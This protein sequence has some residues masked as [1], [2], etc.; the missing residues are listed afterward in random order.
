MKKL[1]VFIS[2]LAVAV[3]CET[4]YGPVQ[5]PIEADKAGG[6]TIKVNSV[7]DNSASFTLTP[8]EESAYYSY[9]VDMADAA[10]ELDPSLLYSCKY[11]SIAQGTVKW[12]SDAPLKT[13]KIEDL[14]PNT[15]YQIYAVAGSP[16]GIAGDIAITSFKTSD[17]VAPV[18]KQ[19]EVAD[20]MTA[21]LFS[22]EVVLG[23]GSITASYYAYND[24]GFAKAKPVGSVT[25]D[26][27]K[28]VI[29]GD[30]AVIQ[31][32]GIPDGA[33]YAVNCTEG[34]FT[35]HSGNPV[36][37]LK[38]AMAL[39]QEAWEVAGTGVYGRK[40]PVEFNLGGLKETKISDWSQPIVVDFNSGHGYGY[41]YDKPLG[42][43]VFSHA[44]KSTSIDLVPGTDFAYIDG[45]GVAIF[46]PEHPE[47][48]DKVVMTIG[49]NT[50]E[51]FYGNLNA[52]WTATAYYTYDYVVEDVLG[53]YTGQFMSM[54]DGLVY[55]MGFSIA[56]VTEADMASQMY[57]QGCNVKFTSFMIPAAMPI[58]AAFDPE[59][60]T[61]TIPSM[62]IFNQTTMDGME[63][64]LGFMTITGGAADSSTPTVW[65]MP[66]R[67]S[68]TGGN[69][70]F[71]I[72]VFDAASG[73]GL[74]WYQA[75][76]SFNAA[77]AQANSEAP[78]SLPHNISFH[79]LDT[80]F[81]IK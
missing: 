55:E 34:T 8:S 6:I 39:D 48:G 31:F 37:A 64:F 23:K 32:E 71:G 51:D 5:T 52:E 2:M 40:N 54:F 59:M 62:Q 30:I 7:G 18:I 77:K 26:M 41:T 22:E 33:F 81:I 63:V 69:S 25:A 4:M 9:L 16:M 57:I 68:L 49:A 36:A 38:S 43:A 47:P 15:T 66:E 80:E 76:A 78:M 27:S 21:L 60:G 70:T 1:L 56:A 53:N 29:D 11:S 10:E 35:D 14:E 73:S 28:V 50:F 45:Y 46:L 75:M 72:Y 3:S 65:Q 67:G 19:F 61:L 12:T 20:N 79:P 58:Y 13:I 24:P 42:S 17:K 44:G 74:G